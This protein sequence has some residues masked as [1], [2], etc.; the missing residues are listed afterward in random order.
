MHILTNLMT[1]TPILH[2]LRNEA[3]ISVVGTMIALVAIVVIVIAAVIAF[4]VPGD[5]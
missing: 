5:N 3:G 2:R 1:A 4:L